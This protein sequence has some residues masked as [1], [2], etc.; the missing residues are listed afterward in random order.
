MKNTR[1][2]RRKLTARLASAGVARLGVLA[3]AILTPLGVGAY[4]FGLQNASEN[5]TDRSAAPNAATPKARDALHAN[6]RTYNAEQPV[7]EQG[8]VP[9]VAPDNGSDNGSGNATGDATGEG[10]GGDVAS[11][12]T[13]GALSAQHLATTTERPEANELEIVVDDA[14]RQ[15]IGAVSSTSTDVSA[16]ETEISSGSPAAARP[17]P[18]PTQKPPVP[19]ASASKRSAPV[20]VAAASPDKTRTERARA[21]TPAALADPIIDDPGLAGPLLDRPAPSPINKIDVVGATV[22]SPEAIEAITAP[23]IGAPMTASA[24]LGVRDALTRLYLENDY[25]NSG[26]YVP[27]QE[28]EGGVLLIMIVEGRLSAVDVVGAKR[29]RPS[30]IAKR[31]WP[32]A[33]KVL[34]RN[35]LQWRFQR[36]VD[37]ANIEKMDAALA[38]GDARGEARLRVNVT[39]A[40]RF[41]LVAA[42][43]SERSPSVGGQRYSLA[44]AARNL[45]GVGD[46][47]SVEVGA[48]RGLTDVFAGFSAPLN[49]KGLDFSIQGG[50]SDADV[51]ENPLNDLDILSRSYSLAGRLS[52][53]LF[54]TPTST[55][56]A[57]GEISY[58]R[59]ETD[60]FGEPFSFSPGAVDGVTE[61]TAL[62][63]G[64]DY[65]ERTPRRVRA[66]RLTASLGLDGR[67]PPTP[68]T[69]DPPARFFSILA[70]ARAAQKLGPGRLESRLDVQYAPRT[71]AVTERF[72]FGG[73]DSVRGYR[74]NQA[75]SDSV[76]VGSVEYAAPLSALFGGDGPAWRAVSLSAFVDG[77]YG[78]NAELPDPQDNAL[79]SVGLA[80]E[81]QIA[82]RATAEFFGAIRAIDAATPDDKSLQ[83]LGLGFRVT[84]R[85]F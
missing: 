66:L 60:L 46:R 38:P 37:D 59:A 48:T 80:I 77:G 17:S 62:R 31:L 1:A 74:R 33:D 54:L 19:R 26:A 9:Q 85:A 73:L 23:Y 25:V 27:A 45:I 34:D 28:S 42:A 39:E 43:A 67:D 68:L 83:D 58:K 41:S 63:G 8:A 32:D 16:S 40:P 69:T 78:Y 15:P 30:Y 4:Y 36:L 52:Q 18:V 56:A 76:I 61:V 79:L 14:T 49:A 55:T 50:F 22:F 53:R 75:L 20:A 11:R 13:A 81:A 2:Q 35:E 29:L 24:I 57:F 82:D 12:A 6:A 65:I 44:G 5:Q 71:L 84:A 10:S 3:A 47:L 51:I 70:Q 21:Q 72:A 64:V 7:A